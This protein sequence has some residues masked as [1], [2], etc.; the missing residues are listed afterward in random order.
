MSRVGKISL[1]CSRTEKA[2]S[3]RSWTQNSLSPGP[4][5]APP[6][7]RLQHPM[8]APLR[9]SLT[10]HAGRSCSCFRSWPGASVRG[11]ASS[12]PANAPAQA[13]ALTESLSTEQ[14]QSDDDALLLL[15]RRQQEKVASTPQG[16][17]SRT[18]FESSGALWMGGRE[19]TPPDPNKAKLGKSKFKP[20]RVLKRESL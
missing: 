6:Q 12:G 16:S 15:Q 9:N 19:E 11:I 17:L 3:S 7:E 1:S 8:A 5:A 13:P 14:S 2:A 18:H 4:H 10:S 20:F